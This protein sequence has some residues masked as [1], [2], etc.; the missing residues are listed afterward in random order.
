MSAIRAFIVSATFAALAPVPAPAQDGT[1]DLS[2]GV[3]GKQR[4]VFDRPP[5]AGDR[6]YAV[7]VQADGHILIAG[8]V[9]ASATDCL[10]GTARLLPGGALDPS[11]NGDGQAA[12]SFHPDSTMSNPAAI[13]ERSDGRVVVVAH[14]Q[15][16]GAAYVG[17]VRLTDAGL[18]DGSFGDPGT[19]G[20]ALRSLPGGAVWI[21]ANAAILEADG[22]IVVGGV[23]IQTGFSDLD[24]FVA[25]FT[26]QG[27]LD[28][29]F[30]G[31]GV[32][33][34]AFDG[35]GADD[36]LLRTLISTG[37]GGVLAAG[38]ISRDF[39]DGDTGIVRLT[40]TGALDTA[41]GDGGRL[42]WE[43]D[44]LFE[45][46]VD[47]PL[48]LRLQPDGRLLLLGTAQSLVDGSPSVYFGRMLSDG[49]YDPTL[50]VVVPDL[51]PGAGNEVGVA[52]D[53]ESDLK[54]VV[55]ASANDR[56]L[57]ARFDTNGAA[58]DPT[59]GQSGV[60]QVSGWLGADASCSGLK[61]TG[62]GLILVGSTEGADDDFLI[63]QLRSPFFRDGFEFG[64]S[65]RWSSTVP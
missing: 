52:I 65:S 1:L 9:C 24:F 62:R 7:S 64:N 48:S 3:A 45:D 17:L 8:D 11:F 44:D 39:G 34:I 47:T 36:D 32:A 46:L 49:S 26:A 40:A 29:T 16:A 15:L 2:F 58:L 57:A 5:F 56:C 22:K 18:F 54:L 33:W 55:V 60:A 31:D 38:A 30:S 43:A 19:P 6:A 53:I 13:L 59:F 37:G 25:R 42:E 35:G 51:V 27:A 10:A 4:V 21:G 28:D 23:G 20:R 63:A 61:R 14:V 12:F 41:F 50:A